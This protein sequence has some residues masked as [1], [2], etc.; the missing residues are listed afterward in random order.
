MKKRKNDPSPADAK[1]AAAKRNLTRLGFLFLNFV[2]IYALFRLLLEISERTRILGIY[3]AATVL[4][5]GAA[6]VLFVAYFILNGFSVDK[7]PRAWEDL[8]EKWT[9]EQKNDFLAK[10]PERKE[11]AKTLLYLLMPIAVTLLISYIELN[12]FT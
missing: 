10:Q 8:P 5:A 11:K 1:N 4:Y 9:D 12:F 3:Y 2:L 7:A 6:V